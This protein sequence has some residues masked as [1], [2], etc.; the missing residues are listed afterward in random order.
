MRK[1]SRFLSE[2]KELRIGVRSWEMRVYIGTGRESADRCGINQFRDLRR[3][4]GIKVNHLP[5][6][7]RVI[8]HEDQII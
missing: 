8:R 7:V 3:A 2:K 5:Q 4:Y 1:I 6:K